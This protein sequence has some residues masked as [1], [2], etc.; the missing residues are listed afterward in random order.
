M[1]G[2]GGGLEQFNQ[3]QIGFG[4]CTPLPSGE[5]TLREGLEGSK[6]DCTPVPTLAPVQAFLAD[7]RYL[8]GKTQLQMLLRRMF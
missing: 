8:F 3:R 2:G 1:R 5:M 7:S 6:K 4:R